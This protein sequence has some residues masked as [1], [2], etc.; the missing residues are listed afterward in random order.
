MTQQK[1]LTW[2]T[3]TWRSSH[4]LSQARVLTFCSMCSSHAQAGSELEAAVLQV[5]VE[6]GLLT[7]EE[8]EKVL[9]SEF[10]PV[11]MGFRGISEITTRDVLNCG[12]SPERLLDIVKQHFLDA[13]G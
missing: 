12:V 4:R 3:S 13:G 10:N 2:A 8:L 5:F 7:A 6:H 9:V 1:P 11:R